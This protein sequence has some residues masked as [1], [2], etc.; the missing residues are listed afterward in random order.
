MRDADPDGLRHFAADY[1]RQHGMIIIHP[2]WVQGMLDREHMKITAKT[3]FD[4]WGKKT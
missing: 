2:D 4:G 1:F 3:T